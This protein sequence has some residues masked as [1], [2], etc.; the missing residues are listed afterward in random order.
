VFFNDDVHFLTRGATAR[1]VDDSLTVVL[2]AGLFDADHIDVVRDL[3]N[4]HFAAPSPQQ[5]FLVTQDGQGLNGIAYAH[6]AAA[7]DRAWYLT[8][9]GVLPQAQRAGV[10]GALLGAIEKELQH[11]RQRLLLVETSA[12]SR[13]EPARRFYVKS[14][15]HEEAR[16]RDFYEDGDDM[17]LF[18]KPLHQ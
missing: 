9:I 14:G 16:V 1:D 10:G 6:A 11:R 5:L 4:D 12:V 3:L 2:A 17:V 18:C 13:F 15:Y 8:M 7:A